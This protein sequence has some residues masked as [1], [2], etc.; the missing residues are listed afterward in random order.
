V[1]YIDIRLFL[2]QAT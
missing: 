2:F 1:Y